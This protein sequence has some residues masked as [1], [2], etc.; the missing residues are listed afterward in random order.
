MY[1]ENSWLVLGISLSLLDQPANLIAYL[2]KFI[3]EGLSNSEH[4]G[5]DH[6]EVHVRLHQQEIDFEF[7]AHFVDDSLEIGGEADQRSDEQQAVVEE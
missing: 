3:I 7:L 2:D 1:V 6:G 4:E 5:V